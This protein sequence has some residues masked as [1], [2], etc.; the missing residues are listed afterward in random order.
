MAEV[1]KRELEK[2]FNLFSATMA[3]VGSIVGAGI[4]VIIGLVA[5]YA[6]NMTWLSFIIAFVAALLT[7][8]S[9]AELASMSQSDAADYIVVKKAFGKLA[10]F[11]SINMQ[12]ITGIFAATSV[13]IGFA[14]YFNALFGT[15]TTI[16]IAG[17]S[18]LF[19]GFIN[20][21]SVKD[22]SIINSVCVVASIIAL[23]LIGI[24]AFV[25]GHPV[26]YTLATQ[27]LKGIFEGSALVFF[28]YLGFG[29]VIRLSEETKNAKKTIPRAIVLSLLISAAF[30]IIIA[31]G[32]FKVLDWQTLSASASPLADVAT[33]IMGTKGFIFVSLA[34]L[35]ATANTILLSLVFAS[36][37][38]YGLGEIFRKL[39]RFSSIGREDTPTYAILLTTGLALALLLIKHLET[40]A[41]LTNFA[42]FTVY[43]LVNGSVFYLRFKDPK[44]ERSFKIPFNIGKF[45]IIPFLGFAAIFFL[46]I[47]LKPVV[48][49]SGVWILVGL[50]ITYYLVLTKDKKD[51]SEKIKVKNKYGK[52]KVKNN[53]KS[54]NKKTN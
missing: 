42:I 36:R 18:I 49:I 3:G 40:V 32:V 1:K 24:L 48:L 26:D 50:T 46:L 19:F 11:F 27:G 4:F 52:T 20:W 13:A 43:L 14:G 9:F 28:A 29:G 2:K 37:G 38:L 23:A 45:A 17:G 8:L 10:G 35:L 31:L 15:T 25:K 51:K 21:L 47:K 12:I 41:E 5:G 53:D 34:A 30:Y 44:A 22:T 6:G 54:K 39:K 16:L 7:G 33:T